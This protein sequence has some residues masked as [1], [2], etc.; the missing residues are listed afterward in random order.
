[1]FQGKE[2]I[3]Q[4]FRRYRVQA[5]LTQSELARQAGCKQ[6]AISMFEAGRMDALAKEK[7]ASIAEHLGITG[8]IRSTLTIPARSESPERLYFCP[9]DA[10]PSNIPYVVRDRL[11]LRPIFLRPRGNEEGPVR[12]PWCG[13]L[14]ESRCPAPNCGAPIVA[15]NSFCPQCGTPYVTSTTEEELPTESTKKAAA[16]HRHWTRE[17][18][19]LAG[20]D[21]GFLTE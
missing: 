10:C 14:L 12:C 4:A 2:T 16:A 19:D 1:M 17:L 7:I 3:H 5:G 9:V 20:A 18:Y 13:E 11:C 8:D 21:P 6:S 15:K